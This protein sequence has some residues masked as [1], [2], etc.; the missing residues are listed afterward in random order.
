MGEYKNLEDYGIIGNLE[1]CALVGRDGSIDWCCFPHLESPS[2]FAAILDSKK[3][4]RF[5]LHPAGE[6]TSRQEYLQENNI[7]MTRF[8]VEQGEL[9]L[10]DFMP[11]TSKDNE[12]GGRRIFRKL[13][14]TKGRVEIL[15]EFEPRFNYGKHEARHRSLERGVES[16][17][18]KERLLLQSRFSPEIE[19]SRV[20]SSLTLKEGQ[21]EWV[22]LHYGKA[23]ILEAGECETIFKET[24][25]FWDGWVHRCERDK[26][27]FDG[28][29]HEQV[30]R[31]GLAL[32]LLTHPES[33]GIAA[34]A[35][36]SLPEEIGGVRN[37]D[38]RYSWIRDASFTVQ[39]L[40]N[41]GHVGEAMDF[42][43]WMKAISSRSEDPSKI[44]I[45]YD[46][47]GGADLEEQILDHLSGYRNS[48]PVRIG[49]GAFD[50]RQHD[51]FG[52]FILALFE[53]TRY[54][55]DL[56]ESDFPF[57][58]RIVDHVSTIWNT[59]DAG[60]WEVRGPEQHFTYSKLMCWVALDR[61]IAIAEHHS[62]PAPLDQWRTTRD[63]IKEEILEKGFDP[64][65][66]SFVQAFG[67]RTLDATS[68]LIPILG[69]LPPDDKR[70]LGTIEATLD[71]L[72]T[73]G[74][75]H[76]YVGDDGLP[77]GEGAFLLC[78]F[79]LVDALIL[80]GRTGEAREIFTGVLKYAG[81]LGLF[82]EEVDPESKKQLG[83]FPQA[84][85]HIGLINSALYLGR[86]LGKRQ[87]G[88]EPLGS[89]S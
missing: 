40:F 66:E 17:A 35:T 87:M 6:H 53:A 47:H 7:L 14:C 72:T 85:S 46:L 34:A 8:S 65:K 81:P 89:S 54:G 36:T 26:C 45:M 69:F 5:S 73:D 10:T 49:N 82:A 30:V 88:P 3:G 29:W 68:L 15:L 80:A 4:G 57:V 12:E 63:R 59:P 25:D 19:G 44:Q 52:E 38:Y 77:G 70:V 61:A 33:G 48:A 67:S 75:V 16:T 28:P 78:T 21:S 1:T 86:A 31:S 62:F 83:N 64:K 50:Q 22:V 27:V 55:K 11:V 20:T 56:K 71:E 39:A 9:V 41:M 32:K 79:W 42:F 43:G 51:I 37:W 60:I 74:L 2:V 18:G 23:G 24:R 76:R 84:F 13:S 58:R